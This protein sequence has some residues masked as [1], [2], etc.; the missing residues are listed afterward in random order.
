MQD[1]Q[2]IFFAETDIRRTSDN[3]YVYE[4]Y[5]FKNPEESRFVDFFDSFDDVEKYVEDNYIVISE[6]EE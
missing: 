2:E 1:K 3:K 6:S 5:V 4:L